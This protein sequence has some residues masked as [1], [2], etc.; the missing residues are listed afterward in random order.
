MN[1]PEDTKRFSL[2]MEVGRLVDRHMQ[3]HLIEIY[4]S[5]R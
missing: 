2:P 5:R 4:T 3:N 1:L